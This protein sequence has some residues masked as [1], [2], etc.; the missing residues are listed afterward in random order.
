MTCDTAAFIVA[1]DYSK[2]ERQLTYVRRERER[3]CKGSVG[4]FTRTI[5]GRKVLTR[6]EPGE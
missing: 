2:D 4:R 3:K 5:S 6:T 1:F